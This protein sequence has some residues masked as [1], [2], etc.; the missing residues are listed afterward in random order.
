MSKW[1]KEQQTS[2]PNL[3]WCEWLGRYH[4]PNDKRGNKPGWC[5]YCKK[6][7]PVK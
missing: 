3:G 1:L 4:C 7:W 2:D 6:E 5:H